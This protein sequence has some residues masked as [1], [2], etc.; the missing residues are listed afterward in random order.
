[1]AEDGFYALT[2][3]ERNPPALILTRGQL[4]DM[5]GAELCSIVKKDI[6]LSGLPVLLLRSADEGEPT[7]GLA[8]E[9]GFDQVLEED[10]ELSIL[11]WQ[12]H[13]LQ[14]LDGMPV[15]LDQGKEGKA[16]SGSLQVLDFPEL[17]QALSQTHKTGVLTIEL[18]KGPGRVYFLRGE[19]LHASRNEEGGRAAFARIFHEGERGGDARFQ[20]SAKKEEELAAFPRSIEMTAEQ[21]LLTITIEKD[22]DSQLQG[23]EP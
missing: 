16:F 14:G 15:A 1:V 5:S 2:M 22:R 21:L 9:E 4:A 18:A 6:S 19:I 3:L 20:F 12:L 13:S 11:A 10:E 23:T 7:S 17:T 8:E